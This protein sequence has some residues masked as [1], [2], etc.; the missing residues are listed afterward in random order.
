MKRKTSEDT[1]EVGT[2]IRARR[3]LQIQMFYGE[4]MA[5]D[6]KPAAVGAKGVLPRISG[7]VSAVNVFQS[8]GSAYLCSPVN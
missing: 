3:A 2:A 1:V 4:A 6:E 8:G 7:D 5:A